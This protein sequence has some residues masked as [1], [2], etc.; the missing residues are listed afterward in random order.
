MSQFELYYQIPNLQAAFDAKIAQM[1]AAAL[2]TQID[3]SKLAFL[4]DSDNF[5]GKRQFDNYNIDLLKDSNGLISGSNNF[6]SVGKSLK[7]I[8]IA[9]AGYNEI[10]TTESSYDNISVNGR[11][12][13][14][15]FKVSNAGNITKIK[16]KTHSS[17]SGTASVNVTVETDNG[18]RPSDTLLT[19]NAKKNSVSLSA[20]NTVY[21]V[22]LDTPAVPSVN[23]LYWLVITVVSAASSTFISVNTT[24]AYANG[25]MQE[26]NGTWTNFATYDMYFGI[27]QDNAYSDGLAQWTSDTDTA[28]PV[29]C[30]VVADE[31]LGT[32]TITYSMSKDNGVTWVVVPKETLADFAVGVGVTIVLKAVITGDAELKAVAWGWR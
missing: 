10:N 30:F 31:N 29:Q 32:G 17:W 4:I 2:S 11:K 21:E 19:A 18:G 14:Q 13:A 3:I 23:T 16:F 28:S 27:Y 8:T 20:A 24:S 12:I 25:N 5:A 6:Y 26:Y 7:I 9:A 1:N 15:S 22:T